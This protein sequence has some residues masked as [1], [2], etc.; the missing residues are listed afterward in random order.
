MKMRAA[1]GIA[2]KIAQDALILRR[3]FLSA[4]KKH[5]INGM[6][7]AMKRSIALD[8]RLISLLPKIEI[9]GKNNRRSAGR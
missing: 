4:K 9:P 7:K 8:Y 5:D 2:K 1:I 3:S 6:R